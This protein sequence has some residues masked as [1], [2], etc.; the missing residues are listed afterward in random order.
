[1]ARPPYNVTKYQVTITFNK[2]TCFMAASLNKYEWKFDPVFPYFSTIYSL[3]AILK[4]QYLSQFQ[5]TYNS[6]KMGMLGKS[7]SKGINKK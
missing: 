6:V 3:S 2:F 4:L 1:M 7:C 5:K